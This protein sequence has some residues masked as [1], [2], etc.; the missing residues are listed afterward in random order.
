M[1]RGAT[2]EIDKGLQKI[3]YCGSGKRHEGR[4][5]EGGGGEE[6]IGL[7]TER[8]GMADGWPGGRARPIRRL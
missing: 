7:E 1:R 8:R 2:N 4:E 3:G 5:E 6:N